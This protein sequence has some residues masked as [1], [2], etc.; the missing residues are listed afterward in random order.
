MEALSQGEYFPGSHWQ[1]VPRR[2]GPPRTHDQRL[3]GQAWGLRSWRTPRAPAAGEP[4]GGGCSRPPHLAGLLLTALRVP[5]EAHA[6]AGRVLAVAV[7][8]EAGA[9]LGG[10]GA[11]GR[12][13][14]ALLLGGQVQR[15][16][17]GARQEGVPLLGLRRQGY[18]PQTRAPVAAR[19]REAGCCRPLAA[20]GGRACAAQRQ[21]PMVLLRLA[22]PE[23]PAPPPPR[24]GRGSGWT[25]HPSGPRGCRAGA[26]PAR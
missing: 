9:G 18:R 6:G 21:I 5:A 20:F 14:V 10:L 26:P 11:V 16:V 4:E 12:P 8:S 13:G 22:L 7:A 3:P 15:G 24:S 17:Q 23:A 25:R 19:T 2:E 1:A